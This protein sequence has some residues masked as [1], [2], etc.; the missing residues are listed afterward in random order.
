M[1]QMV[2][3]LVFQI[4]EKILVPLILASIAFLA[5]IHTLLIVVGVLIIGDM[6]LGVWAAVKRGEA[7]RSARLRDTVSK[8]FIYHLV[9][10]LGY[11]VQTVMIED[12]VPIVKIAAAAIGFVE[13]KSVFENAGVIIGR[14]V[15]SSLISKLGSKNR[16]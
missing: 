1:E 3:N 7:I 14:P 12:I 13:I 15:F 8:M 5:P 9:L 2:G 6:I 16:D 10:I 4:K 11:L